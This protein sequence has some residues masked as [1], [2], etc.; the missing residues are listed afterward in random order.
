VIT[1]SNRIF[2][3]L[4]VILLFSSVLTWAAGPTVTAARKVDRILVLKSERTMQ[5]MSGKNV[6]KTYKVALGGQPVG[7]KQRQGDRKTPEGKYVI[8]GRNPQSQF[9]LSLRISYP[10]AAD[11]AKAKKLGISAG[12][13][14]MIHGIGKT[15][16]WL[17]VLHRKTD[18]TDGCIAV[19]NEEIEEIYALVRLGTAVEIRP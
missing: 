17:G 12:G 16:A 19:T 10:S 9:H 5:L 6:V 13:D 1:F 3:Q 2:G 11:R 18:W 7:A 15:Y 4:L 8:N 14:I